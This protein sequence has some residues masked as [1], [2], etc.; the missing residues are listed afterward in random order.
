MIVKYLCHFSVKYSM[1]DQPISTA[2]HRIRTS[3]IAPFNF[4]NFF[5]ENCSKRIVISAKT[6]C[7]GK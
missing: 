1:K 5:E 6:F 7:P 3:K 4:M 2:R